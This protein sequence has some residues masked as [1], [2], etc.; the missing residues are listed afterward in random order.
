MADKMEE[1]YDFIQPPRYNNS[2]GYSTRNSYSSSPSF[3]STNN[4]GI[5][6]GR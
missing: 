1:G 5:K 3:Y 4:G 2:V 6:Y